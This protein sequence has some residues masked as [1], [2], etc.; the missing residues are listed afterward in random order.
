MTENI[1]NLL[2]ELKSK[3]V[4]LYGQ[5]LEDTYLYGSYARSEQDSES[6]IDVMIVLSHFNSYS[7]EVERTGKIISTLSL[8]YD[9]SISRIFI[10]KQ[11]WRTSDTPLLRNVREEAILA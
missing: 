3:L 11:D 6:D 1:R 8:K 7:A 2:T 10:N 5:Q 9:I 4:K